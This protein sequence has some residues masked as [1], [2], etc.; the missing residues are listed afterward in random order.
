MDVSGYRRH[1]KPLVLGV[2]LANTVS[3]SSAQSR[4]PSQVPAVAETVSVSTVHDF[5]F[6]I[7]R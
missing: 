1:M 4:E 6:L 2:I 5:D 7:G 3:L